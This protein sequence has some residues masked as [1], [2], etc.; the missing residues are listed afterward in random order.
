MY[1]LAPGGFAA[2][3]RFLSVFLPV[4]LIVPAHATDLPSDISSDTTWSLAGS[5]YTLQASTTIRAGVTVT[6][7][8]GV[9]I[10][11]AGDYRLFVN[12]SLSGGDA[13]AP[14]VLRHTD[15]T[16]R[17]VWEGLYVATT[18]DLR[19]TNATLANGVY[20][21]M[22]AG[23][24][25]SLTDCRLSLMSGDAIYAWG[26]TA[27]TC[28][29]CEFRDCTGRGL[30]V[31]G[32]QASGS[33]ASCTFAD[34]GS[35]PVQVKATLLE[36]L[37]SGNTFTGN[38][39]QRVGVSCSLTDDITD[40]DAWP[41]LPI[42][43]ELGA[44][45]GDQVLT[46]ASGGQLTIGAGNTI[47]A[48]QVDCRGRLEVA[49]SAEQPCAIGPA[50]DSLTPGAWE[51]LVLH[52][53]SVGSFSHV[54]LAYAGTGLTA[55]GATLSLRDSVVEHCE[56]DGARVTGASAV[57][58]ADTVFRAN[59]R[60]GLRL[61][62]SGTTGTV[63]GCQFLTNGSHPLWALAANLRCVQSGNVY[64]GNAVQRIGVSCGGSPDLSSGDHVWVR[65][66]L[67][68]DCGVNPTGGV[69]NVGS[70][71]A[72]TIP[73]GQTVYLAGLDV[74]G[75]L[76]VAGSTSEPCLFLPTG[77]T[78]IPGAWN[79]LRYL[80]GTGSLTGAIVRY[81]TNGLSLLNASPTIADCAFCDSQYDGMAC[82]GAS[83]PVVTRTGFVGNGQHGVYMADTAQPNLGNIGNAAVDDD[84]QNSL[85]GNGGY[86]IYNDTTGDI[87]AQNCTWSSTD[88][89]VIGTRIYDHA[90]LSSR[91]TVIFEPIQ[92]TPT[93]TAPVLSWT[94]GTGYTDDG[95]EPT[96]VTPGNTS[97]FRVK[98]TDAQGDAPRYVRLYVLDG[99]TPVDGSPF[100]MALVGSATY[101]S[102]AIFARDVALPVGRNYCYWFAAADAT[103]AATG[104]PTSPQSGPIVN[105]APTLTYSTET[106]YGTDGVAP[107]TGPAG[108]AFVFRCVYTDA[109]GDE[110]TAVRCRIKYSGVEI[111]GSP[112]AM[113]AVG[114]SAPAEGRTYELTWTLGDAGSYSTVFEADDGVSAATGAA[115]QELAGPS[116]TL[117]GPLIVGLTVLQVRSD[118]V[119]AQWRQ[120][121]PGE[122]SIDIRN[123]AGRT[124]AR[125]CRNVAYSS[126]D[127]I[128]QWPRTLSSGVRAPGGTYLLVLEAAAA[129]GTRWR[130]MAPLPLR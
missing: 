40:S 96:V 63:G 112:F 78:A 103:Q 53:G 90:D 13:T 66:A 27:L 47:Y 39:I 91:G 36:M 48:S 14:I 100:I 61:E 52:T 12:G 34:N 123:L 122:V 114:E 26:P 2:M 127:A 45:G 5:P 15:A 79:G 71:A 85:S 20:G 49:G 84:G 4:L 73:A 115:T 80:G 59:G 29:G 1:R 67:P 21:V 111:A 97:W 128:A 62:G 64:A 43:I 24:E 54:S 60:C 25:V 65:Q 126:G 44:G 110:P 74:Y 108:T 130:A 8:P 70:G 119:Q 86:E 3:L 81:G 89:A 117:V 32:Y 11:A 116:V 51:G 42:P 88:V 120:S 121:A 19:L 87:R 57:T 105:T 10:V 38:A 28:T 7:E 77:D 16:A 50:P 41:S 35:Y 107:N 56:Y 99:T 98:Y 124:V 83:A 106:G 129:D 118:L 72:L 23:G 17:G 68:L 58:I 55:D 75:R 76:T 93:G 33:V 6:I 104:A 92:T 82:T 22:T 30:Y 113:T 101:D 31:E 69:L 46:I 18:G 102:G 37:G 125:V 9:E 109:D 94:G 95:V